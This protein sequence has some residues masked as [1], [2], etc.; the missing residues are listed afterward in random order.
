MASFTAPSTAHWRFG[1]AGPTRCK[2]EDKKKG[3]PGER[4]GTRLSGRGEMLSTD[5]VGVDGAAAHPAR[6]PG[7]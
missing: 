1:P 7:Y 5:L 4:T 6:L 2:Y 3:R